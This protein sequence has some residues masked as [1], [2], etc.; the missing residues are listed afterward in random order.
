MN[1]MKPSPSHTQAEA[2]RLIG[3]HAIAAAAT[4][5]I[6]PAALFDLAIV[7]GVQLNLLR[8][9]AKLYK[10]P[11]SEEIARS[12][13]AALIGASLPGAAWGLL[14]FVPI[15]GTAGASASAGA[16]TY[17]VGKVFVQ[18]FESGGSFLTFDPEK[19]RDFYTRE[20]AKKAARPEYGA[21]VTE[22]ED[23]GG[24]QP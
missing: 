13:V 5:V 6:A 12:L 3:Y 2:D 17:A 14:R 15:L 22:D 18:H 7:G 11:F 23:F 8:C 16:S 1:T 24:I 9:L 21:D 4:L 10:Q 19:V 20:A